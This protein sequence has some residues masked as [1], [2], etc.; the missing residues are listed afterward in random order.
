MGGRRGR[1]VVAVVVGLLVVTVLTAA[2]GGDEGTVESRP[3]SSGNGRGGGGD[4]PR[5]SDTDAGTGVVTGVGGMVRSSAGTPVT[6][7]LVVPVSADQP[8]QAVPEM[9]VVTDAEGRYVWSLRP[10]AYDVTVSADG[11][12]PATRHVVVTE[13]QTAPLDFDLSPED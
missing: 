8:H 7:A 2:C 10:G 12:R 1:G 13:G 4:E 5:S 6:G 3:A 9:A 11:H